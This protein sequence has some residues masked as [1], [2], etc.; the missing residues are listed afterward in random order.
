MNHFDLFGI[1]FCAFE[2]LQSQE[3]ASRLWAIRKHLLM[4]VELVSETWTRVAP[5]EM[6]QVMEGICPDRCDLD[7][8]FVEQVWCQSSSLW[9]DP[10]EVSMRVW[11]PCTP[12]HFRSHNPKP[13]WSQYMSFKSS[14]SNPVISRPDSLV[15]GAIGNKHIGDRSPL[16]RVRSRSPPRQFP[17]SL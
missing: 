1:W 16:F 10:S 6:A 14:Y 7:L 13:T 12:H 17:S 9:S 3:G 4:R 11:S 15:Y 5:K 8:S 2:V